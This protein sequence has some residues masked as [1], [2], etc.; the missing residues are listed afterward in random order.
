MPS[1]TVKHNS[2]SR[3][4]NLE[5]GTEMAKTAAAKFGRI[6]SFKTRYH[7]GGHGRASTVAR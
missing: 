2:L 3:H 6:L 7:N 1:A 5:D 4:F